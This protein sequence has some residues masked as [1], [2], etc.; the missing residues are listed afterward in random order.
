VVK[1]NGQAI[2]DAG[3][4]TSAV[5]WEPAEAT[6]TIEYVRDGKTQT[7]TLTLGSLE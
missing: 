3:E 2:L 1:F 5:R 4:L 7:M 6:A